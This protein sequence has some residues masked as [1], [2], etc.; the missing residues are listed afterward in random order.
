MPSLK[1]RII[2]ALVSNRLLQPAQL[3]E[4]LRIQQTQGGSLQKIL[5][6]RGFVNATDL[7]SAVSQGLGI[8]PISLHRITLDP[9]LKTVIPREVATQHQLLPVSCIG[10]TLTIAMADPLN[11]FALET[12]TTMTGLSINPFLARAE[13]VEEAIDRY[14]GTGVEETLE[15]IAHETQ[16]AL[17]VMKAQAGEEADAE[18]LLKLIHEPPVVKLTDALLARAIRL[19]S[20]DLLIEPMEQRVRVRYRVDGVLREGETPPKP[21]H[22]AI[23]SRIKV[24]AEL[25]I[26]E[27][28]LPQDGHFSFSIED[29]VVDVRVSVLPSSFGEKVVLRILDKGQ[30]NL[31]LDDLGFAPEDL[32]TL[33]RCAARPHGMILSTGPT[34]SGKTT[35][36]YALLTLIDRPEKNLITVED[37]VEYQLEGINQVTTKAEIGLTFASALRA[38]LRQDPDVIMIGEIRDAETADMAVKSALTGHLV[39]STLHTNSA[40]GTVVRLVNMGIEPFLINSCLMAV[41]GQRL[42]RKICTRCK[43][44]YLP[45]AGVARKLGLLDAS[46]RVRELARGAG[47]AACLR[48]G[49]RGRDVIAEMLV[50]T[51]EIRDLILRRAQERDIEEAARR[52]GMRTL[53]EHGL[54]KALAHLTSLDEVFRTTMGEAAE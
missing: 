8:P 25:N 1:E 27:H 14:Y 52:T 48:S 3:E 51:P 47:C 54:Q 12:L 53:R 40:S 21:L 19:R 10:R 41:I 7:L 28:R 43:Q 26:A 20:S 24:M 6:D 45:P 42:V 22:Q 15:G 38:I 5:V 50:L 44:S 30:L 4:A 35:T 46:G 13:E 17:D 49:Y 9:K 16:A 11:I 29:R 39:L 36:L 31:N 37:P 33:R 32:A 18:H 23:V 2:H 34:G